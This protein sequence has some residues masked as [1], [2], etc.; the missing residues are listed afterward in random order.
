MKRNNKKHNLKQRNKYKRIYGTTHPRDFSKDYICKVCGEKYHPFST[1]SKY[2]S[3]QCAG[4]NRPEKQKKVCPI[5]KNEFITHRGISQAKYCSNKCYYESI[6]KKPRKCPVC[7]I[8]FQKNN[9]I[10][11][12]RKC[13]YIGIKGKPMKKKIKHYKLDDLWSKVVKIRAGNKCEYCG[14]TTTL[15]SH[16]IFSRSNRSVRW[17]PENG[18][19]LCVSHHLFGTMSAHKAPIEF[20]EWLKDERGTEW[21]EE[22]RIKARSIAPKLTDELKSKIKTDLEVYSELTPKT[23]PTKAR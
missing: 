10:Y 19:C 16:H 4:R 21:Y 1:L 3:V 14:K 13:G 7:G 23:S 11:C 20:V 2:C 22:L 6:K 8:T 15:N 18:V 12:S 5:C 17:L 9:R